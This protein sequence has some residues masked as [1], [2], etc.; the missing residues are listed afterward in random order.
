MILWIVAL[1]LVGLVGMVGYYQGAIRAAASFIGLIAG[2]VLA[3]PLGNLIAPVLKIFGLKHPIVLAFIGPLVVFIIILGAFKIAGHVIHRK[4]DN[5]YKYKGSDTM[6]LLFERLN[7]RLGICMGVVNALVYVLLIANV[8]YVLGY[9]TVQVAS[10][11]KDPFTMKLVN[12]IANDIKSTSLHKAVGPF[13]FAKENY[14]DAVDAAGDI[15]HNPVVQ[16]RLASYPP[17]LP[18]ADRKEFKDLGNDT[19][20]QEF[21]LTGPD[22]ES[23]KNHPKVAPLLDNV[24]LYTNVTAQLKGDYKDLKIWLETG[25]TDKFGDEKIIGRWEFDPGASMAHARKAKP[26][27]TLA[28]IRLLRRTFM[29]LSNANFVAFLDNT[30]RLR[31]PGSNSVQSLQGT[32]QSG[33][34][35]KYALSFSDGKRKLDFPASIEGTKLTVG[36]DNITLVFDK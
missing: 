14:F 25:K 28:E 26:N 1:L 34:S 31:L 13:L 29:G 33:G 3:V 30:A 32:W 10:S 7:Q 8:F 11:P 16:S 18:V 4:V 24:E 35:D 15:F 17:F 9:F 21:W 5:H 27:I 36:K 6:R 22:Y 20:F 2:A 23:F 12:N 19:K